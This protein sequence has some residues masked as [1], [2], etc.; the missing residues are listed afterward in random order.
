M[1]KKLQDK[2]N[3]IFFSSTSTKPQ[4]LN[5][6]LSKVW[7][8]PRLSMHAELL[9]QFFPQKCKISPQSAISTQQRHNSD[10]QF[11]T[12]TVKV[13]ATK[14]NWP[15]LCPQDYDSFVQ[16]SQYR[17]FHWLEAQQSHEKWLKD[18]TQCTAAW[19]ILRMW[20]LQTSYTFVTVPQG[21]FERY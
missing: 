18:R 20:V 12:E 6:V 3:S 1:V 21:L 4:A 19:P 13:H 11:S 8:K 17:L 14:H 10:S 2:E 7:L 16:Y 15:V 9:L 5:I